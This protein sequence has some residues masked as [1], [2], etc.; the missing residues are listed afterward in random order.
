M[1]ESD[2]TLLNWASDG[3]QRAFR[4]LAERHGAKLLSV[5]RRLLGEEAEA[6]D[7]VQETLVRLWQRASELEVPASGIGGW[8]YRVVTNMC[9]DRLRRRPNSSASALEH[10]TVPPAQQRSMVENDLL[11]RVSEALEDLPERQRLALVLF[12]FEGLSMKETA[13]VLDATPEAIES[14]L[15]RGR[16]QL[17]AVLKHE[18]Q[19]LLPESQV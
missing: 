1:S 5:A 13:D 14:L 17:K 9:L 18:W 15:G 3:D 4:A 11:R 12:H 16:R 7:V 6:E 2:A 10:L 19:E 8:L